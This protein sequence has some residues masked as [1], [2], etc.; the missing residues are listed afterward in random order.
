MNEEGRDEDT[1]IMWAEV[2]VDC[3]A[4]DSCDQHEKRWRVYAEGDKDDSRSVEPITLN[5]A[6]FPPGTRVVVSVPTCPE[7]GIDAENCRCGFDWKGWAED[8]YA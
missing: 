7:C 5:V 4:G 2:V 3:Y 1:P 8:R 6:A